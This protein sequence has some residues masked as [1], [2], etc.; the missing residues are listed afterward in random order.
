MVVVI[1]CGGK[2]RPGRWKAYQLYTGVY[3]RE[4]LAA[5]LK[6]TAKD[7]IFILSGKHGLLR[8]DQEVDSYE[9][10]IDAPGAITAS[11][12]AEQAAALGIAREPSV[13][14][15]AGSVYAGI[16]KTVWPHATLPFLGLPGSLGGQRK[17]C[18]E[19]AVSGR[20]P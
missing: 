11:A 20:L 18:R 17:A 5:A 6:L 8:L 10:R 7:R 15:L 2:K 3:F 19:I 4:A 12:V 13:V 14:V 1:P 9:Q 16:A